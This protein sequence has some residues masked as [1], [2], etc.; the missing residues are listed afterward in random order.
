MYGGPRHGEYNHIL[1]PCY[2]K[3]GPQTRSVSIVWE[4]VRN[5]DS[6]LTLY[7]LYQNLHFSNISLIFSHIKV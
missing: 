6:H 4:L 3:D 2:S 5:A 1:A 7:L